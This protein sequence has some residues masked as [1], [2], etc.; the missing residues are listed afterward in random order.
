MGASVYHLG[1]T[2]KKTAM[3]NVWD[4]K[5]LLRG[6]D[7]GVQDASFDSNAMTLKVRVSEDVS[8][9]LDLREM[10]HFAGACRNVRTCVDED[11]SRLFFS[12]DKN[13][14]FANVK[15]R[16]GR[17]VSDDGSTYGDFAQ[18][19]VTSSRYSSFKRKLGQMKLPADDYDVSGGRDYSVQRT[20]FRR[21]NAQQY[22]LK[23]FFDPRLNPDAAF[24]STRES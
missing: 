7:D 13:G 19:M 6:G 12:V 14:S 10:L 20:L 5:W 4:V 24:L 15:R 2:K 21:N 9:H 16:D 22:N 3:S 23:P 8:F 11:G 17:Y 18:A 1:A